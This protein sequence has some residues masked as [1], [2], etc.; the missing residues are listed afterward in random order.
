MTEESKWRPAAS[1][2]QG[3][4]SGAALLN[5][6]LAMVVLSMMTVIL[7]NQLSELQDTLAI[8]TW[9]VKAEAAAE[10]AVVQAGLKLM[11]D[12]AWRAGEDTVPEHMLRLGDADARLTT[13]H[14]R[15]PD[16]VRLTAVGRYRRGRSR[17]V[18][19]VRLSD[20]GLF[21]LAARKR[22]NLDF[23]T[24]LDGPVSAAEGIT[25]GRGVGIP[26]EN[27]GVSV[28]SGR[29][30]TMSGYYPTVRV[31]RTAE[32]LPEIAKIDL[33]AVKGKYETRIANSVLTDAKLA[34]RSI[35]RDGSL[36]IIGGTF[37][38]VSIFVAGD[39]RL[40]GAPQVDSKGDTPVFIVEKDFVA[41]LS[42][43]EIRG[44]IYVGGKATIRG[45][46]VITG[47]IVADEI[48][49]ADGVTVRAFDRD[50]GRKRPDASFFK[51]GIEL[52]VP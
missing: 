17:I 9:K 11:D 16:L 49:I 41:N 2:I 7:Y 42:G 8:R 22:I 5:T 43:A 20:I 1:S 40:M 33:D 23:G 14:V 26:P 6:L 39:L 34:G 35:L 28:I 30:V 21:A 38:D 15:P 36:T 29:E 18:R 27:R 48:D 52:R 31:Y 4:E 44:V 12:S 3:P 46:S 50:T 24:I 45:Q 47:T 51:R 10:S 13:E 32:P 25:L 37:G 19:E